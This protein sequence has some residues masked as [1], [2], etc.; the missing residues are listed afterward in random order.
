MAARWGYFITSEGIDCGVPHC[1]ALSSQFAMTELWL[2]ENLPSL[3]TILL[4]QECF[5]FHLALNSERLRVGDSEGN[6]HCSLHAVYM[7]SGP[8]LE[9]GEVLQ[10]NTRLP[11]LNL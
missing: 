2:R 5:T 7:G 10:T 6:G 11:H 8:R 3:V 4:F 9:A 1:G